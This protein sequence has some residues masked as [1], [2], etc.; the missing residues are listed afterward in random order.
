MIQV[1]IRSA[2]GSVRNVTVRGHAGFAPKGKD[3][4]CAA[5]SALVQ[6][7]LFSL[8]RML[9][10]DVVAEIREGYLALTLPAELPPDTKKDANLLAGSMLVGLEEINRSYP[11]YLEV[12]QE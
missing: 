7:Y 9:G 11:G 1:C 10:I 3:L 12:K 6:T 2:A 4:V 8:R 5:V